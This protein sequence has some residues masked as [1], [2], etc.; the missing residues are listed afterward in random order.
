MD[1][2]MDNIRQYFTESCQTI[3]SHAIITD[4]IYPLV[5]KYRRIYRRI[6]S[7]RISQRVVKQLPAMP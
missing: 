3:T 5:I 7:V 2:P 6:I 4:G 1:I